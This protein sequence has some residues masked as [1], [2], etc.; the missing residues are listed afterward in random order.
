MEQPRPFRGISVPEYHLPD[1]NI[2]LY[3]KLRQNYNL[4]L[5]NIKRGCITDTKH[6]LSVAD[7]GSHG[8][9]GRKPYISEPMNLGY[10]LQYVCIGLIYLPLPHLPI[11]Q[12]CFILM[13]HRFYSYTLNM[14]FFCL[15]NTI[16]IKNLFFYKLLSI[17]L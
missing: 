16:Y 7:G 1:H 4:P 8:T 3:L 11:Q 5:S 2:P 10:L 12:V 6:I 14:I 13:K 15:K 17:Y 9:S